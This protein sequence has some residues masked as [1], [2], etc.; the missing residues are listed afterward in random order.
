MDSS[1]VSTNVMDSSHVS[2]HDTQPGFHHDPPGKW[3]QRYSLAVFK[4]MLFLFRHEVVSNSSDPMKYSPP[5][6]FVYWISKARKLEWLPFPSPEDLTDPRIEPASPA[7]PAVAGRFFTTEPWGKPSKKQYQ[8]NERTQ[9]ISEKVYITQNEISMRAVY[10]YWHKF[11][12]KWKLIHNNQEKI[13]HRD[14]ICNF[15]WF[16]RFFLPFQYHKIYSVKKLKLNSCRITERLK[17]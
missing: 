6:P 12:I 10:F 1:H 5:G 11:T 15:T 16:M 14:R 4:E 2:T 7:S 9:T 13:V 8:W 17:T 3:L